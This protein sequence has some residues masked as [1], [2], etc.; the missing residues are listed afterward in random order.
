MAKPEYRVYWDIDGAR[1]S[2]PFP[3]EYRSGE[4]EAACARAE[5]FAD[6]KEAEGASGVG[7]ELAEP[8]PHHDRADT[9]TIRPATA[10]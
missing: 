4:R 5:A 2:E 6:G 3:F 1:R 8:S 9:W 10:S 7:V